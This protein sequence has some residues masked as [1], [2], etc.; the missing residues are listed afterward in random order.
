MKV[1]SPCR[2]W[3][4]VRSTQERSRWSRRFAH[5][6]TAQREKS[7]PCATRNGSGTLAALLHQGCAQNCVQAVKTSYHFLGLLTFALKRQFARRLKT[8]DW[9]AHGCRQ[10]RRDKS[11][12]VAMF[13]PR[14]TLR[15]YSGS[16]CRQ[17]TREKSAV[18]DARAL[19]TTATKNCCRV[20]SSCFGRTC[21]SVSVA[22]RQPIKP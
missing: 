1:L 2:T 5:W 19:S 11:L 20:F 7:P 16:S 6:E 9:C 18:G 8:C 10:R 14:H 15:F 3:K 21:T 17:Q 13:E 12:V 4:L 22:T